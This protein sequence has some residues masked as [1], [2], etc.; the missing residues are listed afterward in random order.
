MAEEELIRIIEMFGLARVQDMLTMVG[1]LK[2]AGLELS[3]AQKYMQEVRDFFKKSKIQCP[4]CGG[5]VSLMEVNTNKRN[6]V[7]PRYHTL[8]YCENEIDCGWSRLFEKTIERW[9]ED[10]KMPGILKLVFTRN[11]KMP[12]CPKCGNPTGVIPVNTAACNQVGGKFNSLMFCYD[13]KK[14]GYESYS[15]K[16]PAQTVRRLMRGKKNG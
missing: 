13:W 1:E 10:F 11:S 7:D 9:R 12:P 5:P 4:E 8:A 14:C 15:R 3:D 2:K 6:Q 16:T